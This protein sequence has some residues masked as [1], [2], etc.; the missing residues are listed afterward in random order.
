M[1][2]VG[3]ITEYN[4]FHNGHLYQ[5]QDIRRHQ[6]DAQIICV[7]SGCFTQRGEAAIADKWQRAR[8]A[9]LHGADLVLELP[10]VF[11]VRSAQHFA[12]GGTALLNRLGIVN[13]LAF[14]T[15]Y[16]EPERLQQLAETLESQETQQRLQELLGQGISYA[17]A[18]AQAAAAG[19]ELDSSQLLKEPNTILA[20]EYLRALTRMK[21]SIRPMV[22]KRRISHYNDSCI[23]A[24]L[25]SGRAIRAGLYRA[26]YDTSL[27][28]QALPPAVWT[29]LQ[30]QRRTQALPDM[31]LLFRPLLAKL[32]C[33]S[34]E[35]LRQIYA[36]REGL[37]YR[38]LSAIQKSS[39][40]EELLQNVKSKRYLR[41]GLQRLLLYILLDFSKAEAKGFDASGPLYA[42]IL[43]FNTTGRRLLRECR[44]Q[45]SIPLINKPGQYLHSSEREEGRM[46]LSPL[47]QMLAFD[48]LATELYSLCM[49]VFQAGKTDF[50][51]SPLYLPQTSC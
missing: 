48:T 20:L 6:P 21:S 39:S 15:E 8:L 12:T 10:F 4:P 30:Q 33:M 22:L 18:L 34:T 23:H 35:E 41:S 28:S 31:E 24:S 14:G 46:N 49:P 16:A 27:L 36:I 45:A 2:V 38:L 3:I 51:V 1:A 44:H 11:A 9:V 43:A 13:T 42:R 25:A 5:L 47:Q 32:L 7:M 17:S 29:F 40:L 50:T 19:Q 37:E 26:D